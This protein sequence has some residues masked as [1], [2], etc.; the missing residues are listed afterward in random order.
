MIGIK[1]INLFK[2]IIFNVCNSEDVIF[3]LLIVANQEDPV[4][5]LDVTRDIDSLQALQV[6]DDPIRLAVNDFLGVDDFVFIFDFKLVSLVVELYD[7]DKGV[8]I[9]IVTERLKELDTC[10]GLETGRKFYFIDIINNEE[11]I[12]GDFIKFVVL[13][14]KEEKENIKTIR[15]NKQMFAVELEIRQ[16]NFFVLHIFT[17]VIR[18]KL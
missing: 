1:R 7:T 14:I 16:L 10:E 13:S 4:L 9:T 15:V 11:F 5:L 3:K 18:L 8:L 12:C 17:S 6:V 2:F